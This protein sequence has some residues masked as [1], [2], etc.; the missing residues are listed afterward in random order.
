M[1][2]LLRERRLIRIIGA[3]TEDNAQKYLLM[4]N[5]AEEVIKHG[6]DAVITIGEV[7]L[8]PVASVKPYE[9]AADSSERQEALTAAL[10]TKGGMTVE[11]RAMIT[12]DGNRLSLGDT[13]ID[14]SAVLMF[15]APV[16]KAWKQPI[17]DGWIERATGILDSQSEKSQARE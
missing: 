5:L 12:R 11:M 15:F 6:A 1:F 2:F 7:W 17:P 16:Y 4:R 10:I 13:E 14:R 3:Q 9:R 8:A